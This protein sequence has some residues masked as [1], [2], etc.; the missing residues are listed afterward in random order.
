MIFDQ[1]IKRIQI[2]IPEISA[3]DIADALYLVRYL[4]SVDRS[5]APPLSAEHG[6]ELPPPPP[7]PLSGGDSP[8]LPGMSELNPSP[9]DPGRTPGLSPQ[10]AAGLYAGPCYANERLD[11]D[12]RTPVASSLP[13]RT[14]IM[15]SLRLLLMRVAS[16]TAQDLDET[17]TVERI[18]DTRVWQPVM[19][20][21]MEPRFRVVLILDDTPSMAIWRSTVTDLVQLLERHHALR[22]PRSYRLTF[23]EGKPF[24]RPG[25]HDAGSLPRPADKEVADPTGRTLIILVSDGV[26]TAWRSGAMAQTLTAWARYSLVSML[27]VL[28]DGLWERSGLGAWP[29]TQVVATQ[30]G[31][32]NSRLSYCLPRSSRHARNNANAVCLPVFNLHPHRV[33]QWAQLAVGVPG[34]TLAAYAMQLGPDTRIQV[35]QDEELDAAAIIKRFKS[36]ASLTAQRLSGLLAVVAPL[37]LAVARLVQRALLRDSDLTHLAEVWLSGLLYRD[38]KLSKGTTNSEEIIYEFYPGVRERLHALVPSTDA[39]AVLRTVSAYIGSRLGQPHDFR[40]WLN[41]GNPFAE[42][43]PR[44]PFAAVAA[45]VLYGFGG[46]YREVAERLARASSLHKHAWLSSVQM[47]SIPLLPIADALPP[48]LRG[49]ADILEQLFASLSEP[50]EIARRLT[51]QPVLAVALRSLVGKSLRID[52]VALHIAADQRDPLSQITLSGGYVERSIGT[53]ITIQIPPLSHQ[54]DL[55]AAQE[56]LAAMPLDTLPP[57][58][59]LPQLHRLPQ[60]R[61]PNFSGRKDDLLLLARAIKSEDHA[62]EFSPT[63][64]ITGLGGIGKSQLA[65]EFAHRYGQF[66]AGGVFWLLFANPDNIMFEIAACGTA[67]DLP[68]FTDLTINE[69]V[70]RVQAAWAKSIPRLL[71]FDGCEDEALFTE[72]CPTSGGCHV[73]ITSRQGI[74]SQR[75]GI[76]TVTLGVLSR[77]ESIT[78]LHQYRPDLSNTDADLLA[79]ELGDLPLALHL[80]GCFLAGPGKQ[81]T[82]AHYLEE[83]RSPRLVELLLFLDRDDLL[84][85]GHKQN[86]ARVFALSYEQLDSQASEDTLALKV[87]VRAAYLVPGESVPTTL[88]LATLRQAANDLDAKRTAQHALDRLVELGLIEL[89]SNDALRMHRLVG[90]YVRQFSNDNEAQGDVEQAVIAEAANLATTPTLAPISAFLPILRSVTEMALERN[91]EQVAA[92]CSWLGQFLRRMGGYTLAQPHLER[93]LAISEAVLGPKHL[94]TANHLNQL[95][96]LLHA[97][98]N[99]A[100]ARPLYERV[101]AIREQALGPEHPDTAQSLNNLGTLLQAQGDLTGARPYLERA[102]A[103]YEQVLGPDHPTTAQ[104]LNNLGV[105]LQ[106]QGDLDGARPYFERA[107]AM[108]EQALGPSHPGTATS[109]NNLGALLSAQGDMVGARPYYERALAIHEQVLGPAHPT[110]AQSLNNLGTLL[111]NQKDLE[112]AQSYFQRALAIHEQVL[113]LSHPDTATSLNNLGELLQA[114]GDLDGAQPCFV[115]ALAIREQT[116][117][118]E[119]PDTAASLNTLGYLLQAQGDLTEARPYFERALAIYERVLG[120]DHPMTMQSRR[121]LADLVEA[122]RTSFNI[123]F[124]LEL[125]ITRSDTGYV[126]DARLDNPESQTAVT[127]TTAAPLTIDPQS[128]LALTNDLTAYGQALTTQVF[129]APALRDAWLRVRALADGV[130]RPLR[131]RLRLDAAAP[132]LHALRWE[133]LRDPLTGALLALDTRLRL[134]R[135][136]ANAETRP[137]TLGPRPE[138]R[139][140]LTVASPRNLSAYGLADLDVDNEVRRARAALWSIPLMVVGDTANAVAP[141]ATLTSI[142]AALRDDPAILI[143]VAHARPTDKGTVLYLEDEEGQVEVVNDAAFNTM[144]SQLN[145]LPLLVILLACDNNS[146]LSTFGP[147]LVQAGVGAVV[148]MQTKL[149]FS[150]SRNFLPTLF[151]ELVRDGQIDRAVAVARAALRDGVEWATPAVWLRPRDGR[152]W[153]ETPITMFGDR[154]TGDTIGISGNVGTVQQVTISGGSVG[155]VIGGQINTGSALPPF[156]GRDTRDIVHQRQLLESHRRTLAHYLQ[157]GALFGEV[158]TSPHVMHGIADARAGIA[159]A[160]A[161]LAALGEPVEDLPDDTP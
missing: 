104:S 26:G 91:D 36:S 117:G 126:A 29:S 23:I 135:E 70:R 82:V 98:G 20:P 125:V 96:L 39:F 12:F 124:D 155:S 157:Q 136:L 53:A 152:L 142:K 3:E 150:A 42:D 73:L 59:A 127:L 11:L 14:G 1:F 21:R 67:L 138:L 77:S 43:D 72:W 95:A 120:T 87:L 47:G 9:A 79:T 145:Q 141:R 48:G 108:R 6:D 56:L 130:N 121:N 65:I 147:Q 139:A 113:G 116:L 32:P 52:D 25:L 54:T 64:A 4:K 27:H 78:L 111:Y 118:L 15:R 8:V 102:L 51:K 100:T 148:A 115:R 10:P 37:N 34:T 83:L 90:A 112:R 140:L 69:Q 62:D 151:R 61:N 50:M 85:L 93:A 76:D 71:I 107:L 149:S 156:T 158:H 60:T 40:A 68:D 80:A 109:L 161:A 74:W 30:P 154:Y 92:L 122:R 89:E 31:P 57:V 88:L 81:F 35:A 105:M 153:R 101:L 13:D 106:T 137:L 55:A 123:P 28:P 159:K 146:V 131:L 132:E 63:G 66:F 143:L 2:G 110:T 49:Y 97:Q 119:H 45:E 16:R 86:V 134:V 94:A 44:R 41:E 17:R 46:A 144:L 22:N 75:L 38:A 114:R 33:A 5:P 128:L 160:K 129:H 58:A 19:C 103:I 24:L 18:A 84:P 99:Y 7:P 133:S